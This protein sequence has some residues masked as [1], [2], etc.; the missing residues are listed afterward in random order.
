MM[1]LDECTNYPCT[2]EEA[3]ASMERS[4]RWAE[5]CKAGWQQCGAA[6]GQHLFGIVQGS[7]EKDLREHSAKFLADLDLPGYAVGGVVVAFERTGEALRY[8]LPHLPAER[9]RYLMGVGTPHDILAAVELGVDMFDCVL[10]TRN[11]R[12]GKL[13]TSR[14]DLRITSAAFRADEAPV[15]PDCDCP[16]C[17]NYSRAYLR[18]LFQVKEL[19]GTRLATLHNLRFYSNLT[20][21]IRQAI[22]AGEFQRFKASFLEKY[23]ERDDIVPAPEVTE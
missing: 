16:L 17:A 22:A 18:H 12:H 9:P 10:P 13:F 14:G 6:P 2:Y 15:D 1:V 20:R 3:K 23:R 8:S 19:L 5:R 4:M 11:A 21:G 7:F